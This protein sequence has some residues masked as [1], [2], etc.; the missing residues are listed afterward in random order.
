MTYYCKPCDKTILSLSKYEHFK[1]KTRTSF[2][3]SIIMRYVILNPKFDEV[4]E[5]MRESVNNHSKKNEEYDV[6]CLFKKS[7]TTNRVRYI[8]IKP[9]SSL[10]FS[11]FFLEKLF[12]PKI[13]QDRYRFPQIFE[14]RFTF[15]IFHL[16]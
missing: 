2:T 14:G 6:L 4:D 13:N 12:L 9:Q 5:I 11:F 1:S 7:T 3:N 10:H 15:V 8:R 16:I